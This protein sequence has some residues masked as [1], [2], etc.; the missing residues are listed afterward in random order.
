MLFPTVKWQ[1]TYSKKRGVQFF[2]SFKYS[3]F[4]YVERACYLTSKLTVHVL[5]F[6]YVKARVLRDMPH[7]ILVLLIQ[8]MSILLHY[9]EQRVLGFSISCHGQYY[10]C[11]AFIHSQFRVGPGRTR[12]S[13]NAIIRARATKKMLN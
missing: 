8:P 6:E 10:F 5:K 7:S 2:P 3:I 13:P 12:I 11:L 9:A 1:F 4:E